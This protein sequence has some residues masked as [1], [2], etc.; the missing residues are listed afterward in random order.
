MR[1]GDLK[2][3]ITLQY[4]KSNNYKKLMGRDCKYCDY[5]KCRKG[6]KCNQYKKFAKKYRPKRK[7]QRLLKILPL[8][9]VGSS[10]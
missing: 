6:H 4:M 8:S 3:A 5:I 1:L 2:L 9:S 10:T 7:E